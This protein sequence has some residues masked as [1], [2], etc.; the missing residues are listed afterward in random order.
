MVT[1]ELNWIKIN[2]NS[3]PLVCVQNFNS[4]LQELGINLEYFRTI[5]VAHINI[6]KQLF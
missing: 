3:V 1:L 5:K 4:F 6:Q 2:E